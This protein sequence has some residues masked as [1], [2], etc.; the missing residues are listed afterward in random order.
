MSNI[1]LKSY[2]NDE[3][4]NNIKDFNELLK[5]KEKNMKD[6]EYLY[7]MHL[8]SSEDM[9]TIKTCDIVAPNVNIYKFVFAENIEDLEFI[10]QHINLFKRRKYKLY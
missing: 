4:F 5:V 9:I 1:F 3:K 6:A 10:N 8:I 7:R 2:T